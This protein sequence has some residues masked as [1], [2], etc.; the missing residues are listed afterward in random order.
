MGAELTPGLPAT[1]C[2]TSDKKMETP[3]P[4]LADNGNHFLL[5][6]CEGS[7]SWCVLAPAQ[8][9]ISTHGLSLFIL[10]L[11]LPSTGQIHQEFSKQSPFSRMNSLI[12]V[13][14]TKG[15]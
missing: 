12:G 15:H 7:M 10:V 2:M 5:E 11:S 4:Y 6:G 9:V 13:Q 14:I 1:S 3:S 8:H